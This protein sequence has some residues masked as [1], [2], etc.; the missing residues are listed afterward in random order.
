MHADD[1]YNLRRFVTAQNP[2]FEE[3]CAELRAGQKRS[4]WIW[5]IF[6]QMRGLG[7]SEYATFYGIASRGEAE[8]YAA[9]PVLGPRLRE[10]TRLVIA[11]AGRSIRQILGSPDDLKFRSSMTLFAL[12][13]AEN[14][15]FKDALDKHFGGK[16][17]ERTVKLV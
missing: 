15:V 8:A 6:P 12:T 13:S 14:Q 4:H 2:V 11:V 5:F 16:M 7:S 17:D 10:C 3:V 9:H 1:P